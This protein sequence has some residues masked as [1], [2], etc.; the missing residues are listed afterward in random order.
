V[1]FRD[2]LD[3]FVRYRE[4]TGAFLSLVGSYGFVEHQGI[5]YDAMISTAL[6]NRRKHP[7]I[8]ATFHVAYNLDGDIVATTT[9]NISLGG[10]RITTPRSI[11]SGK[12]LDFIIT[13]KGEPLE[14]RGH[15][16]YI[17]SDGIHTGIHFDK[18]LCSRGET[19]PESLEN[20]LIDTGYVSEKIRM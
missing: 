6:D 20:I 11:P 4:K 8:P 9:E 16:V 7:R 19:P 5:S 15:V 13:L 10:M 1:D 14:A 2:R 18:V 17:T 3:P 12:V